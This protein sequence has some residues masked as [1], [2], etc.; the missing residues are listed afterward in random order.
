[1]P[2]RYHEDH[3]GAKGINSLNR[4]N[5]V[6]KFTP[7][8]QALKYQM[9]RLQ[10][11]KSGAIGENTG[12]TADKSQKPKRGDGGSKGQGQKISF[13]VI[14]GFSVISKKTEPEPQFQIYKGRVVLRD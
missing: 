5:V 11:Q 10:W 8:P 1:M 2:H 3:I 7:M 9:R 4:Y 12:M 13:C 6:N 14:D